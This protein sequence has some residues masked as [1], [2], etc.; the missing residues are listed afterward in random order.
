MAMIDVKWRPGRRALRQFGVIALV[1]FGGLAAWAWNRD[2]LAW[3]DLSPGS[4]RTAAAILGGLALY[5]AVGV[6]VA[7]AILRPLYVVLT[8]VGLPIGWVVSH[9]VLALVYYLVITPI[10]LALRLAGRDPMHRRF[11]RERQSY[12]IRRPGAVPLERYFRQY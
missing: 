3:F 12:W 11:E 10:G 6:A 1:F 9:V 4:G 8:A 7:P 2:A 5:A